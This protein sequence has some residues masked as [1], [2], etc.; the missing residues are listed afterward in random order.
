MKY[1]FPQFKVE[2]VD[3]VISI[4]L[5]TIHDKALD[6]ILAIDVILTTDSAK[7]GVRA[8]DMPYDDSWEDS[9][10]PSMVDTWIKQY[11]QA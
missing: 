7:F 5:N 1:I 4:D 11:E 10:I 8:E 3:P 6:K 2:I 9:D